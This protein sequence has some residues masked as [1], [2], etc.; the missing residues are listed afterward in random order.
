MSEIETVALA[1]GVIALLA[2][3]WALRRAARLEA[4][5]AAEKLERLSASKASEA[6]ARIAAGNIAAIERRVGRGRRVT[7][8][9]RE[10]ALE[11]LAVGAAEP[12]IARELELREAEVAVLARLRNS[13]GVEAS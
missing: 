7:P 1:L 11:L 13:I 8:Q 5:L 12:A 6:A 4:A 2:S 10:R 3:A 9:K